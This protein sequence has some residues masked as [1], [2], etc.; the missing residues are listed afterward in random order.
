M[1]ADLYI[2]KLYKESKAK[3]EPLFYDAVKARD[4]E[5][6]EAKR[7]E[8]Q[9]KV[10]EAYDMMHGEGYFRD[11]YNDSNLMN[12]LD[13]SYWRDLDQYATD[14]VMQ[15]D[16]AKRLLE[17]IVQHRHL[18]DECLQAETPENQAYLRE[19]YQEI[20]R[21]L[22]KAIEVNSPIDCSV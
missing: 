2:S 8:L 1:G 4:A 3:Y 12:R 20:V 16:G 9:E 6:D 5:T 14:G 11:S 10:T 19:K 13:F 22:E 21:F 15:P 7:D 18:L 17:Y